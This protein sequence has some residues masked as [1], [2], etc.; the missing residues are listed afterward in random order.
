KSQSITIS[1]SS[2]LSEEEINKMVQDAEAHKAEDKTRRELVDLK[3]Q[4]DALIAQTEKAISENGD[5]VEA[6]EKAKIEAAI[7]D[8][9][10]TLKDTNAT[11]E[12]IETKVKTLTEVSHKMA[13]QMYKQ[14]GQGEPAQ[15]A[16]KADDDVIDAEIE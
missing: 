2:G 4:A 15:A 7:T 10:E 14:E 5:K 3:N 13:E 16:K 1:G 12:Q 9:K 8:L 6:D 11:K